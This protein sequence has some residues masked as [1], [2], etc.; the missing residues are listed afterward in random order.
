MKHI[1]LTAVCTAVL[2]SCLV[3]P[4]RRARELYL[5]SPYRQTIADYGLVLDS[6]TVEKGYD[7][8]HLQE[9][10]A[11]IFQLLLSRRN[12]A[13]GDA[14]ATLMLQA[15]IKERELNRDFKI[16]NTVTIEL[17]LLDPHSPDPAALLLFSE[18]TDQSIESYAYLHSLI[19]RVLR[20]LP[21]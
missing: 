19:R 8:R 1:C 4:A 2:C 16:T 9:N 15:V 12:Q 11:N 10:A 5:A 21:R 3:L 7:S 17:R 6:V 20:Q 18:N 14:E 13:R